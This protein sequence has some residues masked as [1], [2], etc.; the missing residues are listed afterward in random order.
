[1]DNHIHKNLPD[2][3]P[4]KDLRELQPIISDCIL[5]SEVGAKMSSA[6]PSGSDNHSP[7]HDQYENHKHLLRL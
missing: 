6:P 4:Q 1:M 7:T 2:S 3:R 5:P